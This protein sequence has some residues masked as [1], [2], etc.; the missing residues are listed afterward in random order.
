MEKNLITPSNFWQCEETQ[1][2]QFTDDLRLIKLSDLAKKYDEKS[3]ITEK[4]GVIRF[5][6]LKKSNNEKEELSNEAKNESK[7]ELS[8]KSKNHNL[9]VAREVMFFVD[10][11]T[12]LKSGYDMLSKKLMSYFDTKLITK[13]FKKEEELFAAND[14]NIEY[15]SFY[16]SEAANEKDFIFDIEIIVESKDQGWTSQKCSSS[17]VEIEVID[18]K[19][20]ISVFPV[21]C[22]MADKNWKKT[23]VLL[24]TYDSADQRVKYFKMLSNSKN[25]VVFKA[26]C[27]YPGWQCHIKSI[28]VVYR[29]I[30]INN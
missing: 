29:S 17:W 20:E 2:H 6:K 13:A 14:A 26:R 4:H 24:S 16:V 11:I 10:P 15:C 5:I 9:K 22:N 19:N 18:P 30:R 3:Q 27:M 8:K 25:K 28:S 23:T 12:I 7:I 1:L 21:A